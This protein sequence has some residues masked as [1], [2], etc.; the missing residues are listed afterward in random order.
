M[1]VSCL[2]D[3]NYMT[4]NRGGN[5]SIAKAKKNALS[6]AVLVISVLLISAGSTPVAAQDQRKQSTKGIDSQSAKSSADNSDL[7]DE[8]AE[9]WLVV[10]LFARPGLNNVNVEV[11]NGVATLSGKVPTE[12]AKRRAVRIANSALGIDSVRDQ[13]SVDSSLANRREANVADKTLAQRVAQKIAANVQGA[14]AGEDWWFEGWRVEGPYNRWNVVVDVDAP[15]Q[16]TLEGDVSSVDLMEKIV[17][18]AGSVDG[19]RTVD[20]DLQV[21]PNYYS[22]RG[23]S[24]WPYYGRYYYGPYGYY[25]P[26]YAPYR[27]YHEP[28][29]AIP[30]N[31]AEQNR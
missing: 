8:S 23:R 2:T 20:S 5:M 9:A 27:Y 29:A 30:Q 24:L 4:V 31:R 15:G 11:D 6:V 12:Q 26:F 16:I 7:R 19:V 3:L 13:L 25:G 18:A 14:K 17:K 10:K 28:Y 1:A 22:G 21:E